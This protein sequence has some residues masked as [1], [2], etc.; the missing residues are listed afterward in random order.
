MLIADRDHVGNLPYLNSE[1]NFT[2]KIFSSYKT[3]EIAKKL[4]ED[5][6]NI[7]E[8]TVMKLKVC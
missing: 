4:I 7:H 6:V 1:N 5:S 3:I 8:K 2:G